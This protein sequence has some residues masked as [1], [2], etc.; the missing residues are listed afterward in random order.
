MPESFDNDKILYGNISDPSFFIV[1]ADIVESDVPHVL[2]T[3]KD[4]NIVFRYKF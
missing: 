2:K 1:Y 4:K 3:L